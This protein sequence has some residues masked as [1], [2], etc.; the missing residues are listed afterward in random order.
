MQKVFNFIVEFAIM[1]ALGGLVASVVGVQLNGLSSLFAVLVWV[2]FGSSV[3]VLGVILVGIVEQDR[4]EH[5]AALEREKSE[6]ERRRLEELAL[7]KAERVWWKRL[8]AATR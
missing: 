5:A 8:L 2:L 1:S 4:E 7:K 3:F 6:E